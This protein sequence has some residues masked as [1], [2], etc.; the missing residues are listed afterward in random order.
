MKTISSDVVTLDSSKEQ[1][2]NASRLEIKTHP[3]NESSYSK[4]DIK[5]ITSFH[6]LL[7]V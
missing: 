1:N 7:L 5:M 6:I 2:E 3:W 4:D